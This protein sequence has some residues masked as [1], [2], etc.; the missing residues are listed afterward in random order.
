MGNRLIL[1]GF[2]AFW[3]AYAQIA[4][5]VTPSPAA[6]HVGTFLQFSARVSGTST[7]GVTWTIKPMTGAGSISTG[8]RYTPPASFPIP[9]R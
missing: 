4:V 1:V 2:C 8:G 5:T 3:P 6:V 9:T 7:A